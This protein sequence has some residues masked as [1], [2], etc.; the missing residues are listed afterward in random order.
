MDQKVS[1]SNPLGRAG[2]RLSQNPDGKEV[3]KMLVT[4]LLNIRIFLVSL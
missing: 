2:I 4:F 1:G 3:A